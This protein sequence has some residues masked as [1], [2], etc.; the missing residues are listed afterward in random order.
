MPDA[1]RAVSPRLGSADCCPPGPPATP[2]LVAPARQWTGSHTSRGGRRWITRG[3][4]ETDGL[5][6]LP[7][8][9]GQLGFARVGHENREQLRRLGGAGIFA[10]A[11]MCSRLFSPAFTGAEYLHGA[12]VYLAADRSR[13][14]VTDNE[15]RVRMAMR[16]RLATWSIA[17]DHSRDA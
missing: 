2:P 13:Q 10:D 4:W 8:I 9:P 14:H 17:D 3:P 11:V 12:V 7:V 1:V 15:C 5:S 6:S 16:R